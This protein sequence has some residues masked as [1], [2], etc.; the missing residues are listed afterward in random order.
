MEQVEPQ[1]PVGS[2]P[3]VPLADGDEDGRLHYG[4][5]V[6][7]VKLH[8]VVMRERPHEPVHWHTEAT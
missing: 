2:D 4:V 1:L 8:A 3:Q 7:V 6:E 5:G